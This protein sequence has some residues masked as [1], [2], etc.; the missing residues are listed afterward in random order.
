MGFPH[1]SDGKESACNEETWVRSLGWEDTLEKRMATHS[2]ILAWGKG[3]GGIQFMGSQR[4]RY[5]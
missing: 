4:V 2:N 5:D 1:G 3:V